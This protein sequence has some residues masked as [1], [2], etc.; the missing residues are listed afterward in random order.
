MATKLFITP[1][2]IA[3]TTIMGGNVDV[4]K[5]NFCIDNVQVMV[6]EPMLGATLYDKMLTDFPTYAGLYATL[7]TDFIQPIV[8]YQATAE[9]LEV[10]SYTLGNGG[11]FK[12]A[13]DNQEVVDKDEAQFLAQKYS[14]MAQKYVLN[15]NKWI[16]GKGIAEYDTCNDYVKLTGGWYFGK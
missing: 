3:Q 6:I 12:H 11:L 15:F 2:Q 9:Y 1:A 14:A 16:C 8:K 13:P 10:A 7:Y 4:D 5:F